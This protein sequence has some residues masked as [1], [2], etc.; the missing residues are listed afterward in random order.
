MAL[1]RGDADDEDDRE[2][3][4]VTSKTA[5]QIVRLRS[6]ADMAAQAVLAADSATLVTDA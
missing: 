5:A 3:V 2:E 1:G 6:D 4:P